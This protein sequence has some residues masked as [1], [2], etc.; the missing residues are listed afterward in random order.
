[1][2]PQLFLAE[3]SKRQSPRNLKTLI[4][5]R[6]L[7]ANHGIN[8]QS[9]IRVNIRL[10][11]LRSRSPRGALPPQAKD[12]AHKRALSVPRQPIIP[13]KTQVWQQKATAKV[14][15]WELVRVRLRRVIRVAASSKMSVKRYRGS[16]ICKLR[17]MMQLRDDHR[18]WILIINRFLKEI[19]CRLL[20]SICRNSIHHNWAGEQEVAVRLKCRKIIFFPTPISQQE[21]LCLNQQPQAIQSRMRY[22]QKPLSV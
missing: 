10:P 20:F 4:K 5:V 7:S 19:I 21:T 11:I 17:R 1:M 3:K 22:L 12:Q 14:V 18:L 2:Q 16:R 6:D 9:Q 13:S 15:E 8:R